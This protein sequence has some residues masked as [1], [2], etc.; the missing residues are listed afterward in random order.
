MDTRLPGQVHDAVGDRLLNDLLDRVAVVLVGFESGD[1]TPAAPGHGGPRP[2]GAEHL[3]PVVLAQH[4]LDEVGGDEAAGAGD[5]DPHRKPPRPWRLPLTESCPRKL[6][7][8]PMLA[9]SRLKRHCSSSR[10]FQLK[11]L[12]STTK[13]QHWTM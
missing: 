8:L 9:S 5:Q 3:H 1:P 13:P 6:P 2:L 12:Y 4:E 11:R 7:M 10:P